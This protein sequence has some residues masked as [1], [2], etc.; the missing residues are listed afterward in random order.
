[1]VSTTFSQAEV[2]PALLVKD[3]SPAHSSYSLPSAI[4]EC[5][6][7]R[8]NEDIYVQFL[9]SN[10]MVIVFLVVCL[11]VL[12]SDLHIFICY[13]CTWYYLINEQMLGVIIT[14]LLWHSA[15]CIF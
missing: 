3:H 8:N 9:T 11:V 1:M 2:N 13:V 15:W 7:S 10:G 6:G 4:I 12:A 5:R 14:I